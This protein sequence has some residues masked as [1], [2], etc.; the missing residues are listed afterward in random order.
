MNRALTGFTSTIFAEMSA[1]ALAT[2][3]VNLGQGFPDF[4]GPQSVLDR[5][6][7]AIAEG[8]WASVSV[9]FR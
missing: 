1:L 8:C 6:R 9:G 7:Q 4:D 2:D 3:S 5:A